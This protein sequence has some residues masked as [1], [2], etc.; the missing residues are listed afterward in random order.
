MDLP[1][2][3]WRGRGE[4]E[5]KGVGSGGAAGAVAPLTF[6]DGGQVPPQLFQTSCI[7]CT[8]NFK[9]LPTPLTEHVSRTSSAVKHDI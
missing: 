9:I 4:T 1:Y 8:S 7:L 2:A 6:D 3:K 5:H